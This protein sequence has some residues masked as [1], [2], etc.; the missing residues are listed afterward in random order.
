V[1]VWFAIP[2]AIAAFAGSF[3]GRRVLKKITLRGVQVTVGIL[4]L[5]L[6]QGAGFI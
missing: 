4:I 5:A 1:V 6:L 2:A 3:F